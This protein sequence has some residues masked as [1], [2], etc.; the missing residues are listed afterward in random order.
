MHDEL[1]DIWSKEPDI[2][3]MLKKELNYIKESQMRGIKKEKGAFHIFGALLFIV[4]IGAVFLIF[5]MDKQVPALKEEIS[6]LK[7][8]ME[9]IEAQ[10]DD[11]DTKVK[12]LQMKSP[13]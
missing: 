4:I 9:I 3:L 8:R 13:S 6:Q 2:S 1:I 5:I 7:R 12:V 10:V 11:L